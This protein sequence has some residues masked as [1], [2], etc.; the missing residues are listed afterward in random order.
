MIPGGTRKPEKKEKMKT[1]VHYAIQYTHGVATNANTG[2]RYGYYYYFTSRRARDKWVGDGGDFR[3]SP[4][5]REAIPA[6]DAE[7]RRAIKTGDVTDVAWERE[8]YGTE[9]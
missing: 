6:N 9:I 8:V 2:D 7:L 4:D 5:W 3:T 1:R